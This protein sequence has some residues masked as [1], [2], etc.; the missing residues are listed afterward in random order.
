MGT[1]FLISHKFRAL[2]AILFILGVLGTSLAI[3]DYEPEFLNV[4][5]I[6]FFADDE[7]FGKEESSA[8]DVREENIFNELVGIFVVLGGLL[9]LLARRKK[10][11]EMMIQVRLES[12]LWAAKINAVLLIISL[13]FI[14]GLSFYFV[15]V[16]NLGILY[17]LF[18]LRFEWAVS[19]LN[20]GLL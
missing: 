8:I 2:G 17:A 15:M 12:V 3:S 13:L 16:F 11:D 7:V 20:K 14:Y 1:K 19:R 18:A 5:V 10:E 4:D 9:L 6:M